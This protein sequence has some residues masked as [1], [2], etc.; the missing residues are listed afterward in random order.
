M[1]RGVNRG[2]TE[3]L[4]RAAVR[5]FTS[6]CCS[7]S[8][9]LVAS[10]STSPQRRA[11]SV[12]HTSRIARFCDKESEVGKAKSSNMHEAEDGEKVPYKVYTEREFRL[13]QMKKAQGGGDSDSESD[14][15]IGTDIDLTAFKESLL[16]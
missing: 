7:W 16:N 8:H 6:P 2:I 11:F 14:S 15:D 1:Y 12:L 4:R 10:S 3:I 13:Q 5:D 9:S